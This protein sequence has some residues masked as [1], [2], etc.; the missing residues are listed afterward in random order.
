MTSLC[1]NNGTD[2]PSPNMILHQVKLKP[3]TKYPFHWRVKHEI[4]QET[5]P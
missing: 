5:D 2:E 3:V 4:N 1:L